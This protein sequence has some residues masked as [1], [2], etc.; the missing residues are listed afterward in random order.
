MAEAD[1]KGAGEGFLR[2]FLLALEAA[3]GFIV[4][5]A[6]AISLFFGAAVLYDYFVRRVGFLDLAMPL[7]SFL[8]R[9]K[10]VDLAA[11]LLPSLEAQ[12]LVVHVMFI[13][14]YFLL[15]SLVRSITPGA[16]LEDV[17]R[18]LKSDETFKACLV[19][20]VC[21]LALWVW[22]GLAMG[23]LVEA[24]SAAGFIALPL[25]GCSQLGYAVSWLLGG[26][27]DPSAA[28]P[29]ALSTAVFAVLV[30]CM[31]FCTLSAENVLGESW[32]L[33]ASLVIAC[34]V[35]TAGLPVAAL[36]LAI[37]SV[38]R[39]VKHSLGAL[40]STSF[41]VGL[42]ASP[43]LYTLLMLAI[44]VNAYIAIYGGLGVLRFSK[45]KLGV[46]IIGFIT[47]TR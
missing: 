4:V 12:N 19:V 21:W 18:R 31:C 36:L 35:F 30:F 6:C 5:S 23:L 41:Y 40:F 13:L 42:L 11:L 1:G 45:E 3:L 25:L 16:T 28:L 15:F 39:S 43:R 20:L 9:L 2:S 26:G 17:V 27:L 46:D 33:K 14:L 29:L 47:G 8:G 34:L 38:R 22:L 32:A 24:Y 37:L 7:S 44:P 10:G